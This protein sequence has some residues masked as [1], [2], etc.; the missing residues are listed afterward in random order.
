MIPTC[1]CAIATQGVSK[2]EY[3]INFKLR[4]SNCSCNK[5]NN[6]DPHNADD[7]GDGDV[8]DCG[9]NSRYIYWR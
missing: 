8:T 9:E 6:Y 3:N 2:E 7:E 1:R 5:N 4:K